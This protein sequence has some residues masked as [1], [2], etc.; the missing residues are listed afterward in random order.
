MSKNTLVSNF[1]NNAFT[2]TLYQ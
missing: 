1:C 2:P